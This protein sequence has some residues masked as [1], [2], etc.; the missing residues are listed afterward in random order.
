MIVLDEQISRRDLAEALQ[1]YRGP[2]VYLQALRPGTLVKDD[3]L[4]VLLRCVRQPTFITIN[5]PHF[6]R[7][8]E[9]HRGYCILCFPL[10]DDR[11]DEISDLLRRLLRL[12]E[13]KTKRARCGK[14]ALVSHA[15]VQYYQARDHQVYTL[16]WPKE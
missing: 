5:V 7:H 2:V 12:G 16:V 3:A 13:F 9:A 10:P 8:I 4:P 6:W 14:V 15:Q 1:W 11:V